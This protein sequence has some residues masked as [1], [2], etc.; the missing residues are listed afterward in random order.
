MFM[1]PDMTRHAET[2]SKDRTIP[3]GII[4]LIVAY[5]ECSP[6]RNGAR[7]HALSKAG[8]RDI[9]STFGPEVARAVDGFR[10]AYVI[11]AG[12]RIITV[13]RASRPYSA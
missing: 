4:D 9:R 13:A 1:T 7:R 12:G 3:P 8:M 10:S 5:G 2:R 6:A 11:E